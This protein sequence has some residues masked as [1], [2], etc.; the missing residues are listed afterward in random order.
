MNFIKKLIK[1]TASKLEQNAKPLDAQDASSESDKSGAMIRVFDSFGRELHLTR[2]QWRDS[3]LPGTLQKSWS[4]ADQLASLIVQSIQDGFFKEMVSPAKRL[5][6]LES[7]AERGVVL[8]AIVYLKLDRPDDSERVLEE[9][10]GRNGP[11]GTILTNLAKI[12]ATRGDE[13]K[14]L[15]TL[16]RG[17]VLDPNQDNGL[18]WYVVLH[19]EKL[20]AEAERDAIRRVA[21][22]PSSWRPQLWLARIELAE[23][24]IDS[25]LA[26]YRESLSRVSTPCPHDLLFQMSGDLGKAGYTKELIELI[27]PKFVPEVHGLMVGNNLIKA[28]FDLGQ[29]GVATSILEQLRGLNRPDWAQSLNYW[30][31]ALATARIKDEPVESESRVEVETLGLNSPIWLPDDARARDMFFDEDHAAVHVAF[32]GSTAKTLIVPDTIERQLPNMP[33]RISRALPLLLAEQVQLRLGINTQTLIP[34]FKNRGGGF[35]LM[36]EEWTSDAVL[37]VVRTMEPSPEFVVISHIVEEAHEWCARARLIRIADGQCVEELQVPFLPNES[38]LAFATLAS[39]ITHAIGGKVG[40]VDRKLP[41][42]YS[43]PGGHLFPQYLCSLDQLLSARVASVREGG[44]GFLH[45]EHSI[46]D[47]E[48]AQCANL[49]TSVNCRLILAQTL[50]AIK[51][52]KNGIAPLYRARVDELQ[53]T[54]PLAQP[55]QEILGEMLTRATTL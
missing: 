36:V 35:A 47:A 43:V 15:E 45:G 4:N 21:E 54:K 29:Y 25:A 5:V 27:Q 24:H 50:L 38:A 51:Q 23:Q 7:G 8:L 19:K 49:P 28:N 9:F 10:I 16:W 48:L 17:L 3:I 2:Q 1:R 34:W 37:G 12:Y 39:K 46:L 53:R 44:E 18:G 41:D 30:D 42:T 32:I 40:R 26:L 6:E 31:T 11:T 52:I 33:G 14:V 22:L 20:G 13:A 55:A